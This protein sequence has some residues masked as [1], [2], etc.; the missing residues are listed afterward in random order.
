M[1]QDGARRLYTTGHGSVMVRAKTHIEE[2][3]TGSGAKTAARMR[4]AIVIT[5][6]PYMTNKAGTDPMYIIFS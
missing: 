4:T 1:G 6:L 5:E 3:N 2:I